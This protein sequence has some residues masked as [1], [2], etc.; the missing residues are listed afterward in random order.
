MIAGQRPFAD[1]ARGCAQLPLRA[2]TPSDLHEGDPID[3]RHGI[4]EEVGERQRRCA[5]L[6]ELGR[7]KKGDR[8]S[9]G[10]RLTLVA[11]PGDGLFQERVY[12]AELE[13][14]QQD[15]GHPEAQRTDHRVHGGVAGHHHGG[16]RGQ[17]PAGV[18]HG[19]EPIAVGQLHVGEEQVVAVGSEQRAR[20]ATIGGSA[21]LPAAPAQVFGQE[22]HDGDL[23]VYDEDVCLHRGGSAGMVFPPAGVGMARI[24]RMDQ[25]LRGRLDELEQKMFLL[26]MNYEKYF[27]GIDR[28]EPYRDREEIRRTVRELVEQQIKNPTQQFK[29]QGLKA[30][31]QTF[32]LYWTRNLK[33]ME[34]GTH[35]KMRFRAD[36]KVAQAAAIAAAAGTPSSDPK[37]AEQEEVLRERALRM[38]REERAYK[39][40]YD[41]YMDARRQCGQSADIGFDA[42]REALNKQV[43][44]IKST[45][46]VES[47][48]F[49]VV[50]ED[51]KAKVKAVPQGNA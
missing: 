51:G 44:L 16:N 32:E 13:R 4:S 18:P 9:Q 43:R 12:V 39:L 5:I 10:I 19:V 33:M 25:G 37:I 47:V 14:L 8:L 34:A 15:V 23:V 49:R 27:A 45:Y 3:R 17:L 26:K 20:L 24:E 40:V 35:P 29:L 36:T 6:R 30:R 46:N 28:M 11:A 42:V 21:H 41:K 38:E 31:F 1:L 50:V 2:G 7:G 48:K 22:L